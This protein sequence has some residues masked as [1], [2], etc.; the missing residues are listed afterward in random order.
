MGPGSCYAT[1]MEFLPLAEGYLQVEPIRVTDID[2]GIAI[3][4]RDLPDVVA[5]KSSEDD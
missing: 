4:V 5:K 1:E 3:D 2:S